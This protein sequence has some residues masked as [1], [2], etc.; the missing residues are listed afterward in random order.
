M[1]YHAAAQNALLITLVLALG[2]CGSGPATV[3][4][5]GSISLAITGPA[6][7]GTIETPDDRVTLVGTAH[8]D[9]GIVSISW[10]SD[11]GRQGE[12]SGTENWTTGSIPLEMGENAIT[13]VA[14]DGSGA[15]TSRSIV[16]NR[17]SG[18][19]GSATLSWIAPTERTDGS[20]LG[21]LAGHK[22]FYGRLSGIYDYQITVSNPGIATFVV[23]NLGSGD[24]YFAMVAYDSQGIESDRSNEALFE[25][26]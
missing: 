26:S 12:A 7:G 6:S 1:K 14:E 10:V 23:E 15:T 16:F 25:I 4:N 2:A 20:S 8:S 18:Q 22:I 13:I 5:S 9:T 3:V 11:R 21:N 19:T 17:E 24:W